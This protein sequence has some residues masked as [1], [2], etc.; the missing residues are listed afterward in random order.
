VQIPSTDLTVSRLCLGGN[1]FGWSA[2]VEQSFAVLDAFAE[3]GGTFIDTADSYSAWVPGNVGGE[4]ETIIG[5]WMSARGNRDQMVIATKVSRRPSALG[6]DPANIRACVDACLTRLGTDYLDICYA[7][8]DDPDIPVPDVVRTFDEL[9]TAGKVRYAGASNFTPDRLRESLRVAEEDGL[10][11]YAMVQ[12]EYHL[13]ARDEYELG[14]REV[15]QEFGISNLPYY[16]LA[17]GFLTGKYAAHVTVDSVRA[18]GASAYIGERGDRVLAALHAIAQD[19][20]MA[21]GAMDRDA[22]AMGAVALA[23]LAQ[24]PTVSTPIASARTVEQLEQLLPFGDLEL[25]SAELA[26]LDAASADG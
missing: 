22:V 12:D 5:D 26:S 7:H 4:S 17:R 19:R 2:D 18:P 8:A 3:A 11:G 10:A 16:G 6:L 25:T 1:V 21:M 23:W 24:Q 14:M 9:I 13:M 15:V 20:S